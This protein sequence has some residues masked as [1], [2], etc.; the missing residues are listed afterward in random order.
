VKRQQ[1]R[2]ASRDWCCGVA[3]TPGP[4]H[5]VMRSVACACTILA[6]A[7]SP[8]VLPVKESGKQCELQIIGLSVVASP[9]LNPTTDGEPRPVLLRIYQLKDDNALQNASFEQVWKDDKATLGEDVVMKDDIYAYPESL[10]N[11][12]FVRNPD[13][14]YVAAVA[15]YRGHQGK[16]W[17]L[18]F[19]LPP[20]P[21]KGDCTLEGCEGDACKK[22]PNLN[23]RFVLWVDGARVEE[24]S[25]HL[26]DVTDTRRIRNV[27][28]G[29]SGAASNPA[30]ATSKP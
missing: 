6:C 20:A 5:P 4:R 1:Q 8:T 13:A 9:R 16:S 23:P 24:G 21:G 17:F 26:D 27:I 12:R 10:T 2:I 28:L 25:N 7:C 15:L 30:P 19:E 29:K 18:S 14:H 3:K 22:G 11:L